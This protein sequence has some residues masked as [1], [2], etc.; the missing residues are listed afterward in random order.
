PAASLLRFVLPASGVGKV[1]GKR[2]AAA[3][4]TPSYAYRVT[5]RQ[6]LALLEQVAPYMRAYKKVRA[7]LALANYLQVT[8]RNGKYSV[9]TAKERL[10]F[11]LTFMAIVQEVGVAEPGECGVTRCSSDRVEE[12]APRVA[13][14]NRSDA[15]RST[16]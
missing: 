2:T 11:E 16:H 3:H 9:A 13:T 7:D 10:E 8:P 12:L 14:P 6:A 1:T 4:H 5:S 15:E